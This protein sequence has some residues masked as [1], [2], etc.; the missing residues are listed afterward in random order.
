MTVCP[1]TVVV[2]FIMTLI[3]ILSA[4]W[5]RS[6]LSY[7]AESRALQFRLGQTLSEDSRHIPGSDDS[8]SLSEA[9]Q[10]S[11]YAEFYEKMSEE[12]LHNLDNYLDKE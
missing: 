5:I 1:D 9:Q 11:L 12:E 10:Y 4:K 2:F 6:I 8:E 3:V 7:R